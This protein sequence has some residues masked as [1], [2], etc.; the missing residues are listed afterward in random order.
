MTT[1]IVETEVADY[2]TWRP[3]FDSHEELRN[4]YGCTAA[5]VYRRAD[6]P[7]AVTVICEFPSVDAAEAFQQ[8]PRLAATMREAGVLGPPTV[9]YLEPADA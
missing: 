2:R 4:R 1:V 7:N 8:D 6:D 5:A 9:T 3:Q